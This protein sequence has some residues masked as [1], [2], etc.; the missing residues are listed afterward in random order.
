MDNFYTILLYIG[1]ILLIG[2]FK[3]ISKSRKKKPAAV[4]R[5][6]SPIEEK[7]EDVPFDFNSVFGFLQENPV[8]PKTEA[9]PHKN[10]TPLSAVPVQNEQDRTMKRGSEMAIS[11]PEKEGSF[12]FGEFDLPAAIVYSEILKRPNY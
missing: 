12:I 9:K 6:F 1:A 5:T 8:L 11:P 4:N 2:L 7:K 10:R 3:S